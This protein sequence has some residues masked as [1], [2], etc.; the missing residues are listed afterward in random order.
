MQDEV[1]NTKPSDYGAWAELY[2]KV[3]EI[4]STILYD[5]NALM[6]QIGLIDLDFSFGRLGPA[7]L[8]KIHSEVKLLLYRIG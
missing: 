4:R 7:D 2:A 8:R 6:T 5:T 3:M 1:L